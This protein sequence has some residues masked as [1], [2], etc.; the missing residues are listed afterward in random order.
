VVARLDPEGFPVPIVDAD[1]HR[2]S[3]ALA[4][5]GPRDANGAKTSESAQPFVH[6]AQPMRTDEPPPRFVLDP[7]VEGETVWIDPYRAWFM[8][9]GALRLGQR[10]VV[11]A[12]GQPI[13]ATGEKVAVDESWTFETRPPHVGL[14]VEYGWSG[15]E[16][17]TEH[18]WLTPV[19]VSSE[20]RIEKDDIAKYVR[21]RAWPK[22]GDRRRAKPVEIRV[23]G[24]KD[25]DP[26]AVLGDHRD[27]IRVYP[28]THWP[29]GSHVA[30][31]I[32]PAFAPPDAG[33]IATA[34]VAEFEVTAGMH[35]DV[36]CFQDHGDG[37]DPAGVHIEFDRPL[38]DTMGKHVTVEPRPKDLDVDQSS[39]T[40]YVTGDFQPQRRYRVRFGAALR[41]VYGQPFVGPRRVEVKMVPPPPTVDLVASTGIVRPELAPTV[42]LEARYVRRALLRAAMPSDRTWAA[43]EGSEL[44][45]LPFPT[46]VDGMISHRRADT[47]GRPSRSTSP[48]SRR[49]NVDRCSWRWCRSRSPRP[50]AGVR[51]PRQ[52]AR[53]TSCRGSARQR[54]Y[55]TVRRAY[56]CGPS[57]TSSR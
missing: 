17:E 5:L 26:L 10:Y 25:L 47:P 34:V 7:P 23:F 15:D 4:N 3:P 46:D 2:R 11:R 24:R 51:A 42:G 36:S 43:I 44:Q 27:S 22:G 1:A 35:A 20:M 50:G 21:A 40:V 57:R 49:A 6:F 48:S 32:D 18:H 45:D 16:E 14:E 37:C 53:S 8:P 28:R 38:A 12:T 31:E 56:R 52:R 30:V 33:P 13:A 55:R 41:D 9:A 39:S 54:G 29:A 19:M